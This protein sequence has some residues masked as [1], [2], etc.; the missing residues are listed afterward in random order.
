[1]QMSEKPAPVPAKL[2]TEE[3]I[4]HI[5]PKHVQKVGVGSANCYGASDQQ[6][7]RSFGNRWCSGQT[8]ELQFRTEGE[9]AL[10]AVDAVFKIEVLTRSAPEI[11]SHIRRIVEIPQLKECALPGAPSREAL[12]QLGLRA[13][14]AIPD[15]VSSP[16]VRKGTSCEECPS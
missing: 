7:G 10:Q 5:F 16:T 15:R 11:A 14:I 3:L 9:P 1:M 12:K 2:T 13:S 8:I 4:E 6:L